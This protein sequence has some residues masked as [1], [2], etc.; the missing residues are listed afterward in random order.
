MKANN[1]KL[2][3][4]FPHVDLLRAADLE[5]YG[6][7]RALEGN[8]KDVAGVGD[9]KG[10]EIDAALEADAA[11][12]DGVIPVPTRVLA[13]GTTFQFGG[14]E[15][16]LVD[17]SEVTY[18][19]AAD[20]ALFAGLLHISGDANFQLNAP[21][22]KRRYNPVSGAALPFECAT[23][24]A[25]IPADRLDAE[26]LPENPDEPIYCSNACEVK[27][28]EGAAPAEADPEAE[29]REKRRLNGNV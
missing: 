25:P 11:E 2:P 14:R 10:A 1:E 17:D 3:D 27:A 8:Y 7:V 26:G 19:G 22:L 12:T 20:E 21:L 29:E 24:G 5:T 13:A 9:A 6:E 15:F 4:D 18:D 28:E 16:R 23:C